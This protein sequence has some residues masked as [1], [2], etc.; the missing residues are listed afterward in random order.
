MAL[1]IVAVYCIVHAFDPPRLNWGDSASDYNVMNSGLNFHK[2][3][4]WRLKFTP[5]IA[6]PA[7]I[8][9]GQ[10]RYI[11]T[12]YPQLPDLMNGFLRDVLSLTDLAQF[13]LVSLAFSF[14]ALFFIYGLIE[15]YWQREV[16]QLAIAIWVIN[17][18]WLQHAD[19]LHQCPY[20]SFFGFGC[21][22]FFSKSFRQ[23]RRYAWLSGVFLF[24]TFLSSYDYWFFIP[25][26]LILLTLKHEQG[27]IRWSAFNRLI[28]VGSFAVL[29]VGLKFA[30][31]AWALGGFSNLLADLHFQYLERATNAVV[32]TDFFEGLVPTA[33]GRI[34]RCFSFLFFFVVLGW[35]AEPWLLKKN[36]RSETSITSPVNPLWLLLSALPFLAIFNEI[37]VG[38]YY[39]TLL[40]LPF[41]SVGT[42]ALIFLFSRQNAVAPKVA[43]G[44]LLAVVVG[45]S[46][47]QNWYFKKAFFKS[48]A[49]EAL[50][51]DLNAVS[52]P[53]QVI[54][55]NHIFDTFY[56]YYF[57]RDT[58]SLI[59][60]PSAHQV[61]LALDL[62]S[63]QNSGPEYKGLKGGP[64]FI[65]HKHIT[66]QL[67]DKGC[68]Y[69]L[70]SERKWNWW[71]NPVRYRKEI[72]AF[73]QKRNSI[74]MAKVAERG[75]MIHETDDYRV[76]LLLPSK[77][78]R[79]TS[80]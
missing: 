14:M 50:R 73:V 10:T 60:I 42:A 45:N 8:P 67:F 7:L 39:P 3:G 15:R 18:L 1:G 44:I 72:D 63:S 6:D 49:I 52:R 32:Q 78:A 31:N 62:Y 19:Y 9:P 37:W 43:A 12:H 30:T 5:Y 74:L 22:Y 35:S 47:F 17:P 27:P 65:E 66:D 38:Q 40:L 64:V 80:P 69:L 33:V 20:A 77:A 68:Y 75:T 36:S 53:G 4:F 29:A 41:A 55:T 13:R 28:H 46:L 34:T 71:G 57:K 59:I 21:L 25:L 51:L 24:F 79:R 61:D 76:W 70:A 26:L 16:A 11:Y 58:A 23:N 56:R 48:S 54:L 2:Y